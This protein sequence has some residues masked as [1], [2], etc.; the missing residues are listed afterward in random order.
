MCKATGSPTAAWTRSACANLHAG[1]GPGDR[2]VLA[3]V[4][5][6]VTVESL[7]AVM[8]SVTA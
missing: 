2:D 6:P 4:V 1:V 5:E 7:R 8:H 3:T